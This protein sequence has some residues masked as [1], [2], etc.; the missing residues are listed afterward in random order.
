MMA[1]P[2]TLHDDTIDIGS[3]APLFEVETPEPV[4]PFTTHYAVNEDGTRFL[5]NAVVDQP[6]RP[7]IT[8]I[9]DWAR[10]L[11]K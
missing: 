5:V 11:R 3:S 1:V 4:A 2:V 9:T 7:A 8:V 10:T 6:I